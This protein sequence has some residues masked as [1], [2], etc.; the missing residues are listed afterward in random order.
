[1][2]IYYILRRTLYFLWCIYK[3]SRFTSQEQLNAFRTTKPVPP[4]WESL[5]KCSIICWKMQILNS[6][7]FNVFFLP[8]LL[9]DVENKRQADWFLLAFIIYSASLFRNR[10]GLRPCSLLCSGLLLL[11]SILIL[12]FAVLLSKFVCSS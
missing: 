6:F 12:P 2:N 1:M 9:T 8:L 10:L 3:L 5:C 11:L 4:F 7:I